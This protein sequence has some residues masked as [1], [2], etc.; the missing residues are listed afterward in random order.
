METE[1]QR[2]PGRHPK[3]ANIGREWNSSYGREKITDLVETGCGNLYVVKT[4]VHGGER[5]YSVKDI[6]DTIRRDE[7]QLTPEY[8]VDLARRVAQAEAEDQHRAAAAQEARLVDE[9]LT[10]FTTA[11]KYNAM[12]AGQAKKALGNR[13]RYEGKVLTLAELVNQLIVCGH[14]PH[15]AEED[16]IKPMSRK[17]YSRADNGEQQAHD[18]KV[19]SAGKKSVYQLSSS[20]GRSIDVGAFGYA[21]ALYLIALKTGETTT[22][23]MSARPERLLG[24]GQLHYFAGLKSEI[25]HHYTTGGAAQRWAVADQQKGIFMGNLEMGGPL[26]APDV[27]ITR[28]VTP[29]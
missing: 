19:K 20:D 5:R 3:D 11:A 21:Y 25:A 29:T 4:L 16:K 22:D 10:V 26:D 8:Q 27:L 13:F 6:E 28:A 24:E 15:I 7:Y 12:R 14:T 2:D 17:D 18:R 9:R 23:A 1:I